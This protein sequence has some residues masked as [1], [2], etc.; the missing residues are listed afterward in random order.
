MHWACF[1]IHNDA[2]TDTDTQKLN[3]SDVKRKLKTHTIE[4]KLYARADVERGTTSKAAIA[5][6]YELPPTTHQHGSRMRC[7][8]AERTQAPEEEDE[9]SDI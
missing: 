1:F 5:K 2:P 3:T 7:I 9:N 6:K 8:Q 4:I